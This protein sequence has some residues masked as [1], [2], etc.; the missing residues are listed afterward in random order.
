MIYDTQFT[1]THQKFMGVSLMTIVEQ[2]EAP[3]RL[4]LLGQAFNINIYS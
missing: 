2:S 3:L 1:I 4:L